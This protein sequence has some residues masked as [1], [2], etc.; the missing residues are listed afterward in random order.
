MR[1]LIHVLGTACAL[2]LTAY[3]FP[4]I[5]VT[6][7]YTAIVVAILL[8]IMNMLVRPL[9]IFF[10]LPITLLTFGL[11]VF[12]INATI[13]IFIASFVEGFRVEGFLSALLGSLCV[14]IISSLLHKLT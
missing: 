8:G 10:T 1:I 2:L 11:F 13:F 5:E 3:L 9:L 14:S 7:I 12:V 4:S 6:G